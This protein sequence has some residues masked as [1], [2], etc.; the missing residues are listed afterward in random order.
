MWS[1]I[2]AYLRAICVIISPP[3]SLRSRSLPNLSFAPTQLAAQIDLLLTDD[4]VFGMMSTMEIVDFL[5]K[6]KVRGA[7]EIGTRAQDSS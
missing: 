7:Q 5:D 1:A 3:R 2:P 6:S 4:P